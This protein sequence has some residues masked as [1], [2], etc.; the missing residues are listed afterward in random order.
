MTTQQIDHLTQVRRD[1]E[2]YLSRH[3]RFFVVRQ[4]FY[5]G[6]PIRKWAEDHTVIETGDLTELVSALP[7]ID[8][9]VA[10]IAVDVRAGTSADLS[11]EAA[12]MVAE[13]IRD[14][15]F[16]ITD[17]LRNFIEEQHGVGSVIPAAA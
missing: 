15:E 9:P 17:D 13:R 7:H 11:K 16:S 14:G 2:A 1:R 5:I 3:D 10:V 8:G 4:R 12:L 6:P